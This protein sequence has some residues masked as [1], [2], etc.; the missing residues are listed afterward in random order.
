MSEGIYTPNIKEAAQVVSDEEEVSIASMLALDNHN[1]LFSEGIFDEMYFC[2]L[3]LF[4][5][6]LF[7]RDT[8]RNEIIFKYA[9]V[10]G[11]LRTNVSNKIRFR[12]HQV[13]VC[14]KYL[15][16]LPKK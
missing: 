10:V 8:V 13:H 11:I 15:R 12:F 4:D 14:L 7:H 1:G 16:K 3:S 2:S 5:C 6:C 9:S